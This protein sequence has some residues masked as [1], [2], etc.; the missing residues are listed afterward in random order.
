[1]NFFQRHRLK[2][3]LRQIAVHLKGGL[4]YVRHCDFGITGTYKGYSFSCNAIAD[5]KELLG[6]KIILPMNNPQHKQVRFAKSDA[7]YAWLRAFAPV[8]GGQTVENAFAPNLV[9]TTN[10]LFFSSVILTEDIKPKL[11]VFFEGIS[12]GVVYLHE[13]ELGV[14]LPM[15][16]TTPESLAA[17]LALLSEIKAGFK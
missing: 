9:L 11:K 4:R 15:S 17:S 6:V 3:R 14:A 16:F 5:N 8:S 12:S 2:K 1:M 13:N 10:D 7:D